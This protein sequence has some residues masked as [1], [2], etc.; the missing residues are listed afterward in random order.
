M[1]LGDKYLLWQLNKNQQIKP[2][3]QLFD[4]DS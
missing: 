4:Y 2:R 1:H 3:K